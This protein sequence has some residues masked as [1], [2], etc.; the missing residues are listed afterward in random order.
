L[1]FT[2]DSEKQDIKNL[3][4]VAKNFFNEVKSSHALRSQ[5]LP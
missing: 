1:E 4:K 2:D 5:N 3:Q